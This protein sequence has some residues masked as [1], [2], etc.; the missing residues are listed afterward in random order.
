MVDSRVPKPKLQRRQ[1]ILLVDV[2]I[3]F[4]FLLNAETNP[5]PL[6]RYVDQFSRSLYVEYK[7]KGIDVQCQVLPLQPLLFIA[8]I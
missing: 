6:F 5:L 2:V 8:N 3:G 4:L 7:N 1:Y